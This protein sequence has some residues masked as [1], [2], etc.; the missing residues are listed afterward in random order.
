MAMAASIGAALFMMHSSFSTAAASWMTTSPPSRQQPSHDFPVHVRQS[1]ARQRRR[2]SILEAI[3]KEVDD[4]G[5]STI[6]RAESAKRRRIVR[7]EPESAEDGVS[8]CR[9]PPRFV[10]KYPPV[11]CWIRWN[12]Y[13]ISNTE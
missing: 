11:N 12:E 8:Q 13:R 2:S 1:G 9:T 3:H 4:D 10:L 6:D 5:D 7:H